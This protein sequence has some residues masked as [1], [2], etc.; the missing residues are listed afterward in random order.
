MVSFSSILFAFSAIAGVLAA[1]NTISKPGPT[2]VLDKRAVTSSASGWH[3]GFYYSWWTD[4]DATAHYTNGDAG[5]YSIQW[6]RASEF[7]GG[8]G[9]NPGASRY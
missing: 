8:K 5:Q 7:I 1:P 3:N 2:E 6:S 9:W 4:D